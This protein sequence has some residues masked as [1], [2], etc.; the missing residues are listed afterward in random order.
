MEP[1]HLLARSLGPVTNPY[2][3]PH[4]SSAHP[5]SVRHHLIQRTPCICTA[6]F[7]PAHTLYLY[8]AI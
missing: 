6:P 1:E 7:N 5:V 2:P 4:E 8:G 3:E